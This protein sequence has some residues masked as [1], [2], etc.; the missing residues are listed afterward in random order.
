MN[1]RVLSGMRPT[2]RLHIGHL[3]GAL[4][5][6]KELQTR[7]ECFYFIADWHALTTNYADPSQIKE[8]I[9]EMVA[10]WIACGIDPEKSVIFQQSRVKEHSELTLLLAM[11]TPLSWLERVPSYKEMREALKDRDL[12]TYG[13]LGYPLLQTADIIMYKADY[14]PVGED[15]VPHIELTRKIVRRFNNFYGETFPEPQ[16][17]LTKAPKILGTDGRKMSKSYENAIFLSDTPE[18]ITKKIMPMY[19]DPQ[20]LRRTDP[21]NPDICGIYYLH[22]LY[23]APGDIEMVNTECRRAGIGCVDCKKL[24]LPKLLEALAPIREKRE[25]LI[26]SKD[27]LEDVIAEGTKRAAEV[28]GETMQEVRSKLGL[29]H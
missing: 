7:H 28:A 22:K 26:R 12:S 29:T 16:P 4:S 18:E 9:Y 13:F 19:T 3:E 11:I 14:V 8:S 5:S 17:M 2:G 1:S 24:L 27:Y 25:E 15:Q 10:D 21:G 20:R 6:W 23:S